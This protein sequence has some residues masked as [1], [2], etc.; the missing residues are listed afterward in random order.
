MS[1]P[2]GVTLAT[3]TVGSV[4]DFFGES[5]DI[6]VT[7]APVLGGDGKAKHIVHA[8]SGHV[9]LT[10]RMT[11]SGSP[12]GPVNF[13]V[14]H[15][16]QAGFVT[17]AGEAITMWAYSATVVYGKGKEDKWTKNF[18]PLVG[19][20]LLDLDLIPDGNIT[21]PVSAP[22]AAVT[23]VNG[24]AGAVT[25]AEA[26][27]ENIEA[28]LPVRLSETELSA[29]TA[30]AVDDRNRTIRKRN[31]HFRASL[32]TGVANTLHLGDSWT[33]GTRGADVP[34]R[35]WVDH[36]ANAMRAFAPRPGGGHYIPSHATYPLRFPASWTYTGTTL[37][38]D[39]HGFG[40]YNM[41]MNVG[42][43]AELTFK[44]SGFRLF[45]ATGPDGATVEVRIDGVLVDTYN[46]TTASL[47]TGVYKDYLGYQPTTHTIS[48][49]VTAATG[50][51]FQ[52]HGAYV[53]NGD[54]TEGIRVYPAGRG[55]IK[56]DAL[57][58]TYFAGQL[59]AGEPDLIT[60]GYGINDYRSG[61]T[62]A[63]FKSNLLAGVTTIRG[64][65]QS[66]D[67][68]VAI[69]GF[70]QPAEGGT[71]PA[72]PWVEFH[73]AAREAAEE[74]GNLFID[75]VPLF[76]DGLLDPANGLTD[77]D[78]IHPN[79]PGHRA[80]AVHIADALLPTSQIKRV[81]PE[82]TYIPA[83]RFTVQG[84]APNYAIM[85]GSFEAWNLDP[86]VNESVICN[87][88][89]PA[90]WRS[91]DIDLWYAVS[92][93]TEG[94]VRLRS[95]LG[96]MTPGQPVA[97]TRD[98]YKNVLSGT[99]WK[100]MRSY[101]HNVGVTTDSGS[102]LRIVVERRADDAADTLTTDLSFLGVALRRTS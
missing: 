8:E 38:R 49:T 66:A 91:F 71:P 40:F 32:E 28:G 72:A 102:L 14:P 45:H 51:I 7:V 44:G 67:A 69:L 94:T 42:S 78:Q 36:L 57:T 41:E 99:S 30:R 77:V 85:N 24:Q 95:R 88:I 27:P 2:A 98:D 46:S 54:E 19:Q 43:T 75:L 10:R 50:T 18:Q 48:L 63:T 84:G 80:I 83:S 39:A 23:T 47:A 16:D 96:E 9:M 56:S 87:T 73:T 65:T 35:R 62:P 25:V 3:I 31:Q 61:V 22:M 74:T 64:R 53:F 90:G 81:E 13:Q 55:G 70:P 21:E 97:T 26:T 4:I 12:S 33:E 52:F 86:A 5:A 34:Y 1:F 37:G 29:T 68:T 60:I 59:V 6:T 89:V 79:D 93:T 76:G 101:A 58:K 15:V 20:D 92:T 17:S 82:Q 100:V 11:F